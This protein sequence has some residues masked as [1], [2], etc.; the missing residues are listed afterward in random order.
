LRAAA[1]QRNW[2]RPHRQ[3]RFA[4]GKRVANDHFAYSMSKF[5]VL[6]LTHGARRIGW[7][8]G[9]RV[10]VICPSFVCVPT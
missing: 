7:D 10:T 6:A 3:H 4:I 5:A 8:K 9:I 1:S 2:W